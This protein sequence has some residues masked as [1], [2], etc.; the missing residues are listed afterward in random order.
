MRA[1]VDRFMPQDFSHINVND[2]WTEF[3]TVFL[4]APS[5]MTKAKLGY[6]WTI[7]LG[8]RK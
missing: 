5:E 1:F 8:K 4:K 7:A 6:S 3:K 2:M